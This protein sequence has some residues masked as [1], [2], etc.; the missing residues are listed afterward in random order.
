MTTRAHPVPNLA[1]PRVRVAMKALTD[2][3]HY[4]ETPDSFEWLAM[5]AADCVYE[6]DE[7]G[8]GLAGI[9]ALLADTGLHDVAIGTEELCLWADAAHVWEALGRP[10]DRG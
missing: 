8:N 6:V 9:F 5:E 4:E 7:L 3:G 10:G 1:D 2:T